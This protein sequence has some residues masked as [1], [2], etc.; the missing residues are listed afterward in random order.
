[1]IVAPRMDAASST[2]PVPS[3][4]GTSPPTTAPGSGGPMKTPNVKPIA[5]I[6]TRPMMTNS[7]VRGPRRDC[8]TSSTIETVPVMSPPQ[9]SGMPNSRF[10]ATAPPMTSAMS[11]AMA[12]SSACS[13]YARRAQAVADAAAEHLGQALARDDAELGREVLDEP[14]HD[15]AEHDDPDE[16]VAVLGAGGHVARDVARVEVGDARDEGR[17]D[18][19]GADAWRSGVGA[20]RVRASA[21]AASFR[22]TETVAP[23]F[24]IPKYPAAWRSQETALGRVAR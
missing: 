9:S 1:M 4:R 6:A 12:T 14:R 18:Q 2:E 15:V 13:Q 24:G 7:K 8:T 19:P 21:S 10:S 5:M 3:K 17:P 20:R 22:H 11:V 23:Y 16:Q